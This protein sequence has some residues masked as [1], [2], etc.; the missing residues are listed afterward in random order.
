MKFCWSLNGYAK[1]FD[2]VVVPVKIFANFDATKDFSC[3]CAIGNNWK[4]A[5]F[6]KKET[7]FVRSKMNTDSEMSFAVGVAIVCIVGVTVNDQGFFV[8]CWNG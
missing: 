5:A 8:R 1:R 3:S 4:F 6:G 2:D 7:R